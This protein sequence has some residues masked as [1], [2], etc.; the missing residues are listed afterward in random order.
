MEVYNSH[1]LLL[2]LYCTC[3]CQMIQK[4]SQP[5]YPGQGVYKVNYLQVDHR[6]V[7]Y[8]LLYSLIVYKSYLHSPVCSTH[9]FV[10]FITP[11]RPFV[12]GVPIL[13]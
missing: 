11:Q 2:V 13:M 6:V 12:S 1:Y 5:F 7:H 9:V 3:H 10:L 4:G 8:L